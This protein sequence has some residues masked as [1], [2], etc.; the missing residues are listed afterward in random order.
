MVCWFE[1]SKECLQRNDKE[2]SFCMEDVEST[3][4]DFNE[5]LSDK[6]KNNDYRVCHGNTESTEYDLKKKTNHKAIKSE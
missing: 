2:G 4:G 1:I 6:G 3:T 5:K